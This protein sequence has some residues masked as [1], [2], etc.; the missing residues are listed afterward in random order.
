MPTSDP[1]IFPPV[2]EGAI[3]LQPKSILDIG[4]GFGAYGYLLRQYL[5][6]AQKR[7]TREEWKLKID[8][9][10]AFKDY[11]GIIQKLVYDTIYVGDITEVI[12]KIKKYDIILLLGVIEHLDKK[13]GYK[14][15]DIL[16][17]RSK[18]LYISTPIYFRNQGAFMG[19]E[20]ERHV[21]LWSENDFEG[22]K[23]LLKT[24]R[25]LLV[26]YG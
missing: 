9:V 3:K 11:I 5:E 2:I 16:K 4:C 14:I 10:E 13:K 7:Y 21:S 22:S 24:E 1:N 6:V 15:L 18:H 12:Y 8:A 20:Y 17:K 23:T 19:N 25:L 26:K